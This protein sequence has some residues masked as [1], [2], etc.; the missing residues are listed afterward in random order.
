MSCIPDEIDTPDVMIDRD[1]LDRNI[2]RMSSAVAAK[3]IALRP[4]VKTHKLPEIAQM[5]LRAGARG[6]TVATIGEAEVFV[7]HGADDVFIAY[8]LWIGTRQADRLRRLADHARIAIGVDTAEG[9]SNTGAQLA[10]AAGAIDVLIEIDSGHHRSGVRAEQVLE[11]AHA[12]GEAGL[13]LVGV[14][15]FPG[16][17]YAPGKS[18]EA[19]EQERRALNDAANALVAAGF[20]ISCRSGGSTPTALLTAADGASEVRPGVYVLGDA[21]QLELG[22]CAPADIALTVAATVVSRQDCR[23]GLRRIVLDCGSKILGS[24]RPAWA[25]GFGRLIDHADARIA[26]LSEHHATVVWPDDAPLPPVGTRLRVI[27][28]HVCLTTNLVDDVAVVRDATL[29]DRWKV[30]ARGKNH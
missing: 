14:F 15:T 21:Q 4:H 27:P 16:H 24:D 30:A 25:T 1:I 23:S 10:D 2:G 3:G 17:S 28:N 6:L 7:D 20:P 29:I 13:H 12:V 18:G 22:R 8:P 11:V 9:A 5:Q 19:A 26:A